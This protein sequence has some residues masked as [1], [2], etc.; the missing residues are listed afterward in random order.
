MWKE[1]SY[2]WFT[3]LLYKATFFP[4]LATLS[5]DNF[6][7]DASLALVFQESPE[8]RPELQQNGIGAPEQNGV[9][10]FCFLLIYIVWV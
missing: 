8:H 7:V 4:L 9:Y 5:C 2:A 6:S 1:T 3:I 10:F